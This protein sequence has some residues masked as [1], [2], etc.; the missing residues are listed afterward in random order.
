MD[1]LRLL[2]PFSVNGWVWMYNSAATIRPG[3]RK[4]NDAIV[5]RPSYPSIGSAL[6]R[7]SPLD[8][9]RSPL[10]Q[11]VGP[12]T[13]NSCTSTS[14]PTCPDATPS[15]ASSFSAA[16]H[17]GTPT[18]FTKYQSKFRLAPPST[19][20]T[21]SPPSPRPSTSP[22][23]TSL[24]LRNGSISTRSRDINLFAAGEASSRSCTRPIGPDFSALHGSTNKAYNAT[25]FASSASG[26]AP[27]HSTASPTTYTGRCASGPLTA[28]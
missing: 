7:S 22:L 19:C 23:M 12:F 26:W 18:T 10:S 15:L 3:A 17:A 24:R 8:L 28:N 4:G 13:T 20:S 6:S 21:P 14:H 1:A 2:S 11:M 9:H 27:P 5:S 16:N 25:G